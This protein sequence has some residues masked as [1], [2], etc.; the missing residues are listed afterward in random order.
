MEL[1]LV[2][3]ILEVN[4]TRMELKSLKLR[5]EV[6]KKGYRLLK[7]K[8]DG[9]VRKLVEMNKVVK[10]LGEQVAEELK[11]VFLNYEQ[12]KAQMFEEQVNF[13]VDCFK[14]ESLR[15][16][17]A[18]KNVMGVQLPV[19]KVENWQDDQNFSE[20]KFLFLNGSQFLDESL[21]QIFK[22]FSV[23]LKK[24]QLEQA[25]KIMQHELKQTRRRVNALEFLIMPKYV[26]TIKF[27][28]L[29]LEENERNNLARLSK[30]KIKNEI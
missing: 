22:I 6:A 27:I 9:M 8:C 26:D 7:N 2:M 29:K 13:Y 4:A 3:S 5:L 25:V 12:S 17:I 28:E 20:F 16:R 14:S 24:A 30:I 18:K 21:K 1:S 10:G 19:L 23:L 15:A 11:E